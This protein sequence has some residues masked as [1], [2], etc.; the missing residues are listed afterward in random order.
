MVAISARAF[1]VLGIVSANKGTLIVFP[2]YVYPP[3]LL[4]FY[5]STSDVKHNAEQKGGEEISL[6]YS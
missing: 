4:P 1:S 6:S 5:C 3:Y 2:S